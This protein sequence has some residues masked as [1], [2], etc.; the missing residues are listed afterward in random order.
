MT[1]IL[2]NE[3]TEKMRD[4]LQEIAYAATKI[5]G[6]YSNT[7]HKQ[8]TRYGKITSRPF[9]VCEGFIIST[10]HAR[11]LTQERR[12]EPKKEKVRRRRVGQTFFKYPTRV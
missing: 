11:I 8:L 7:E 6:L 9:T 12:N 4:L 10:I 3:E 2:S 1:G 5:R